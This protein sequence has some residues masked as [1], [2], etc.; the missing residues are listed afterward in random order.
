MVREAAESIGVRRQGVPSEV[1]AAAV[2]LGNGAIGAT[3]LSDARV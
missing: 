3:A 1:Y 2:I